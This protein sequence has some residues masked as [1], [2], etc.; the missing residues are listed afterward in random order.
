L[1]AVPGFAVD[2]D[3]SERLGEP[4]RKCVFE[5][6]Y[7]IHFR[8]DEES[9]VVEIINFRHGARLPRRGEP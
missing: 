2:E 7:L 8:Q 5:G 9:G 3:A 6:T 4:V 1:A